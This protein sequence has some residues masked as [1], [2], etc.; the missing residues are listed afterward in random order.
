[1]TIESKL[2]N[3]LRFHCSF[4]NRNW[5]VNKVKLLF[6]LILENEKERKY[7]NISPRVVKVSAR[8]DV[9]SIFS[10]RS[11]S[12]STRWQAWKKGRKKNGAYYSREQK[13]PSEVEFRVEKVLIVLWKSAS[14]RIAPLRNAILFGSNELWGKKNAFRDRFLNRYKLFI[15]KFTQSILGKSGFIERR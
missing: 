9:L 8:S 10:S 13:F 15:Y 1:M 12:V 11:S 2:K 4:D 14:T 5:R 3:R 7:L 6:A